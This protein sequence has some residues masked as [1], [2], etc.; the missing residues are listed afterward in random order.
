MRLRIWSTALAALA[1]VVT[2]CS[3]NSIVGPAALDS[4]H[5]VTTSSL[6]SIRIS[7]FHYDN[8]GTDTGEA[9]E[10]SGPAGTD[11]TGWTLVLYNG[12]SATRAPYTT[13]SLTALG[14]I[15]ATC[16]TRGVIVVT[17]GVNGIQNG[18]GTATGIDPDG[19]ALVN[20]SGTVI[21]FLSYEG[22]FVAAS[23]PAAGMTSTDIG[24]REVGTESASPV[25]SLKRDGAGTWTGPSANNFGVC[26]DEDLPPAVVAKVVLTPETAT[27]IEGA[28]QQFTAV[29]Y[30]A[31]DVAIPGKT[32][33][34]SSDDEA[35]ATVNATGLATAVSTGDTKIIALVDGKA[36]TAAVHVDEPPPDVSGPVKISEIHYDNVSGDVGEAIEIEGPAGLNLAGWSVVLY[37]L[38]GG[39]SYGTLPLTGTI[40]SQCDSRGTVVIA[41]AGFQNGPQDGLALVNASGAVVEFLS[42][43]GT[44]TATNGPAAGL[45]STDIGPSESGNNAVGTSLM[46]YNDVW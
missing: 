13:T 6:P 21:E 10:I 20:S 15:P 41:A 38:T 11:L 3:E 12:S 17:Y 8:T 36:D 40:P 43:E 35:I 33:T 44:L 19:F 46:R 37:N 14:P 18:S 4:P 24:I 32:F 34:W 7:E 23:G 9:V 22:S 28:T 26:N 29:A 5:Y 42:Y 45:T 27:V 25:T 31:S 1:L 2:S 30:D 16:N 39:A